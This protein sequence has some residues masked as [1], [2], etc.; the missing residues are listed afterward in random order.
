MVKTGTM[1]R[2]EQRSIA[3]W[4]PCEKFF[5]LCFTGF[6]R[7]NRQLTGGQTG[8]IAAVRP[9]GARR[10][11]RLQRQVRQA[12]SAIRPEIQHR[13]DRRHPLGQTGRSISV[14]PT[15]VDFEG[16]FYFR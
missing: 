5:D 10:S 3:V 2:E 14:R 12:T 7:S 15:S 8:G 9:A 4:I 6:R 1:L 16:N 11:D 13:S